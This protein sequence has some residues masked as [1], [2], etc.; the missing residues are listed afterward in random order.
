M[1]EQSK[2]ISEKQQDFMATL[3]EER[4]VE[5]EELG[6]DRE[7]LE[8]EQFGQGRASLVIKELLSLPKEEG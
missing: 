5:I 1:A 7:L 6:W 4:G 3:E 2:A 8:D